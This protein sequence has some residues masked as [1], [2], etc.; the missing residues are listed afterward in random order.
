VGDIQP[1][2]FHKMK[3]MVEEAAKSA[4]DKK[5]RIVKRVQKK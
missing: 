4:I 3:D 5:E 2:D 1:E